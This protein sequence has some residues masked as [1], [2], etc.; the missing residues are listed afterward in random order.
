MNDDLQG[1]IDMYGKL[2]FKDGRTEDIINYKDYQDKVW[3]ETCSGYYLF[4]EFLV[5]RPHCFI[6][7]KFYRAN[8]MGKP[9]YKEA[10]DVASFTLKR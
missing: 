6:N 2:I 8:P 7:H 1:G 4:V 9:K 3:F 5:L 10:Y